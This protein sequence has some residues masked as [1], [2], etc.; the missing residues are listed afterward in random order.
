MFARYVCLLSAL[1]LWATL[2]YSQ[3]NVA[4]SIF[5]RAVSTDRDSLLT[6]E[7]KLQKLY[8]L[9]KS[10]EEDGR[11][12]DTGYVVL[13]IKI[14]RN[15]SE[16]KT[17][18]AIE[19]SLQ[20]LAINRQL[21]KPVSDK[22][23]INCYYNLA[24]YY[25][26][27]MQ[28]S[29]AL[30]CYDS[31]L[32]HCYPPDPDEYIID[33]RYGK[34]RLYAALADY[35]KEADECTLG[36]DLAKQKRD[37]TRLIPF[38]HG[39]AEALIYLQ[40]NNK[41]LADIEA[42]IPMAM[43]TGD[44]VWLANFY[45]RLADVYTQQ[46][47]RKEAEQYYLKAIQ[48]RPHQPGFYQR[49]AS[50]YNMLAVFYIKTL[51]NFK[52]A[53]E[54]YLQSLF[55]VNKCLPKVRPL[56]LLTAY[57]NLGDFYQ[58]QNKM[59]ASISYYKRAFE[60]LHFN[61]RD[62]LFSNPT[63]AS[64]SVM[65]SHASIFILL[66]NKAELLLS[67]YKQNGQKK[68][69]YACLNTALLTDSIITQTRHQNL[70]EGSKLYWRDETREFFN[71]AI[72]A[73]YLSDD[74]NSAFYFMEKSRAALLN[75][76][77]NEL[78]AN[79]HLP[80]EVSERRE[81]FQLNILKQ[82]QTLSSLPPSSRA[83]SDAQNN[84]LLTIDSLEHFIKSLEKKYPVYYQDKYSDNVPTL[85]QLQEYLSKNSQS[86]LYYFMSDTATYALG[87][88]KNKTNLIRIST[89]DFNPSLLSNFIRLCNN[90]QALL[91]HYEEYAAS[92]RT[93]Y[94]KLFEPLGVPKGRV[95]ICTDNF[96][97]PFE[98]LCTDS[99]G[100]NFLI[101]DYSFSYVYSARSL[102]RS[103][104]YSAPSGDFIG[105]APV[106]FSSSLGVLDLKQS[107][108]A[109][110]N[111]ANF[112]SNNNL[113]TQKKATRNNFINAASHYSVVTIFSHA[114]A[115]TTDTEPVLYMQDSLIHLS[116]LQRLNNPSVQL[117]LLSA[118]QT[119]IGRNATGEGIY[120]LARGFASAGIPAVSATLWKADEGAV[121]DIS[122]KFNEYLAQGMDKDEALQKAKRW[123][124]EVNAD[125]EKSLPFY[126]ANLV[127]IGNPQP[128][129]LTT[130]KHVSDWVWSIAL[131]M[132]VVA[133]W[134]Y[135]RYR[136]N[137]KSAAKYSGS[138][139]S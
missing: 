134:L 119:N 54:N 73:S 22:F 123:Y 124:L 80:T 41:A 70:A 39:R 57:V 100:K 28:E 71:C 60:Q 17:N 131:L 36:I 114:K 132:I 10:V 94:T 34:A 99:K 139:F 47:K 46:E 126:W 115:D 16:A 107:A 83:Y 136:S 113:F 129:S 18:V 98:A 110:Q 97:I 121:Y 8:A 112:Y 116:D 74:V 33:S 108:S 3:S 95:A 85:Q 75:D 61:T 52:K 2:L 86:L 79:Q 127:L 93:I 49:I 4:H 29:K 103:F 65:E 55:Y 118:C 105:F 117:V 133:V 24:R 122:T 66:S 77:W 88:T 23:L 67:L 51:S 27:Q 106:S 58:Q 53:K 48:V 19:Y 31:V 43:A 38:L 89:A 69:L 44:K 37:T 59:A 13:L 63:L 42:A 78:S 21:K 104:K 25:D 45:Q 5:F 90:K 128:I 12:N 137:Q 6:A 125:N 32:A 56:Y 111:V 50:D 62:F 9:K 84:L 14:A 130:S 92:S 120:S 138:P 72:E 7:E 64:L 96:F 109:L 135:I 81:V 26:I 102:L 68:Y 40:Q 11:T 15:E 1:L 82:K 30:S 91:N 101:N 20:A 87:I 35:E 76:K